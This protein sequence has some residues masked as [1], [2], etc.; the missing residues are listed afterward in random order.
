MGALFVNASDTYLST[1]NTLLT[2]YP[3][4]VGYWVYPTGSAVFRAHFSVGDPTT[5]SQYI[6]VGQNDSNQAELALAA[7]GAVDR[8]VTGTFILNS[9]NYVVAR[10]YSATSRR[11]DLLSATGIATS[12]TDATNRAFPTGATTITVG[13]YAGSSTTLHHDGL[14]AEVFYTS[15]TI[16]A[17]AAAL[18]VP[19]LRQLAYGGPFSVPH[20]ASEV[21]EYRSLRSD[22]ILNDPRDNYIRNSNWQAWTNNNGVTLG[23]HPPLPYWYVRPSQT[24]SQLVI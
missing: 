2:A 15:S 16:Q 6:Q 17:D 10:F 24:I 9:W 23:P 8:A 7:G 1:A 3:F 20:V 21:S 4:S 11:I 18:N 22:P 12:Q 5:G 19:M 14:I 13:N